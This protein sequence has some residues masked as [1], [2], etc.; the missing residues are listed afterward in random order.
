MA[1]RD[2]FGPEGGG[3]VELTANF[4]TGAPIIDWVNVTFRRLMEEAP[5]EDVQD[6]Q[7]QYL[8]LQ[9]QRPAAPAQLN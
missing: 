2:H 5:D 7:P 3:T 9:A 8:D 6:S 4:R 1:A